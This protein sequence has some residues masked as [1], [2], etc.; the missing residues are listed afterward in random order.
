M[1]TGIQA[2]AGNVYGVGEP[3]NVN[4]NVQSNVTTPVDIITEQASYAVV[5]ADGTTLRDALGQLFDSAGEGLSF[6]IDSG[7]G[8]GSR[9]TRRPIFWGDMYGGLRVIYDTSV[10]IGLGDYATIT[11]TGSTSGTTSAGLQYRFD[12]TG[13][14]HQ[15]V[16]TGANAAGSG[17]VTDGTG[18]PGPIAQLTDTTS[19]T[20]LKKRSIGWGYL[21]E[22][23][24]V[25]RGS[26]RLEAFTPTLS[27]SGGLNQQRAG[28]WITITDGQIGLTTQKFRI[29]Q[30]VKRFNAS[31]TEEWDVTFGGRPPSLM[32]SVRKPTRSTLS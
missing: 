3:L 16:I 2:I 17:I 21:A 22:L 25:I 27:A 30:I 19:D 32:R 7:G 6:G 8:G 28:G 13:V 29:Y 20:D 18:L 4:S 12:A 23:T 24:S 9:L 11:V 26:L 1:R 15:V 31:G 10:S 14:P 5:I